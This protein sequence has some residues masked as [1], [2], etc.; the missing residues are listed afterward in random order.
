M[1]LVKISDLLVTDYVSAVI[2]PKLCH[3]CMISGSEYAYVYTILSN[4]ESGPSLKC[5]WKSSFK[6]NRYVSIKVF[7]N[8]LYY[9]SQISNLAII[10]M[11]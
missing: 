11:R 8:R 6:V 9:I 10:Y 7:K 4:S 3:L 2:S 5:I 1:S